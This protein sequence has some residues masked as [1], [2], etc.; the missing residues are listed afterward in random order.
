MSNKNLEHF[1]IG[2][3]KKRKQKSPFKTNWMGQLIIY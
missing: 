2:S 3:V 1:S